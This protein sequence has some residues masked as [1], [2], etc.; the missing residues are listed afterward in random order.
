MGTSNEGGVGGGKA[1]GS[2]PRF[3]EHLAKFDEHLAKIESTI[4]RG[5]MFLLLWALKRFYLLLFAMIPGVAA[6]FLATLGTGWRIVCILFGLLLGS[7][8]GRAACKAYKGGNRKK[9]K[10]LLLAAV[11]GCTIL[12]TGISPPDEP[13]YSSSSPEASRRCSAFM[14]YYESYRSGPHVI[15][16]GT[17]LNTGDSTI[18]ACKVGVLLRKDGRRHVNEEVWADVRI[19]PGGFGTVRHAFYVGGGAGTYTAEMYTTIWVVCGP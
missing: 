2:D 9:S 15:V 11:S 14:H 18:T 7:L 5:C 8:C 6:G 12:L 16:V 13:I 19:A 10:W 1:G 3:D 4:L 17:I